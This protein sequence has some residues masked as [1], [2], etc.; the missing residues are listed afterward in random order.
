M[1]KAKVTSKGQVT[2]PID[3]RKKIGIEPGNY[4]EIKETEAGYIIMKQVEGNRFKKYTGI[5]NDNTTSD[6]VIRKLRGE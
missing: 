6:E 2:L 5:L 1:Y 3:L 4:I